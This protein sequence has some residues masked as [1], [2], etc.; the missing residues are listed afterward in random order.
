MIGIIDY[1][2]GNLRSVQKAFEHVG[3]EARL[4]AT[5]ADVDATS[6]AKLVLPGVGAFAD[7]MINLR[8]R[9][10]IDPIHNFIA[11][12]RPFLGICLGL[13]L[14][15]EGSQEDAPSPNELVPGLGLIKGSVV[16]F[17]N[18]P[19]P[20]GP[21]FKVPHMGWNTLSVRG[22]DPLFAGIDEGSAVYFVHSYY[23]R[24][25]E[26]HASIVQ[27]AS[28]D[29]GGPFCASVWRDNLWA[30]QFH[31]EKSQNV[32]LRMLANFAKLE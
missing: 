21:R 17:E 6:I 26:S 3:A 31:P 28:A 4:L 14:L 15:F 9:G 29:Y 11:S 19:E 7:G 30:T 18:Q 23:A 25:A 32:G 1:G 20:S 2:M 16:R 27:S 13:Q 8:Q 10:W 22:D 5:P 24:P 12:G